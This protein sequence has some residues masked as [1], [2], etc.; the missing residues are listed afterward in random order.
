[1]RTRIKTACC[2][3]ATPDGKTI[4]GRKEILKKKFHNDNITT[5]ELREY[6]SFMVKSKSQ[7]ITAVIV[8]VFGHSQRVSY[9]DYITYYRPQG[10][11]IKEVIRG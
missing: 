2:S 5:S 8:S 3:H 9:N 11:E 7:P 6:A 1:M 4:M 10:Y